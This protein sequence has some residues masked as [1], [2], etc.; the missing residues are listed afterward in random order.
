MTTITLWIL[1][2]V[3]IGGVGHRSLGVVTVVDRF[4]TMAD[5]TAVIADLATA[6]TASHV[7]WRCVPARV[8]R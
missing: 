2:A 4:A 3:Q 7:Q 8:A 5:C 1:I 6:T